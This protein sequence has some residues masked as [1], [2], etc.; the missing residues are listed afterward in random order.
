[1]ADSVVPHF[2]N[3]QGVEKI[4][5]GVREFQCM[6]ARPPFDHPHVIAGQGTVGLELMQQARDLGAEPDLVLVPCS[7]GGLASGIALA[8]K[9]ARPATEVY[10]VEPD[11]FD[12]LARSLAAG[13]R[14]GNERKSGSIC[15]AL[16]SQSTGAL[17]FPLLR[18]LLAGGITVT[19]DAVRDAVR[20]AATELK[21][22]VEPGGAVGLAAILSGAVPVAGR[23]AVVVLSG[24]NID[25]VALAALLRSD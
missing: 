25:P 23:T 10:A 4:Y 8:V 18:R 24:G 19:D 17:T 11:G 16:Q 15:D 12:D 5:I 21:L 7:G 3:D 13:K 14:L 9:Q 22:V 2:A 6:G 20:Y 1:M